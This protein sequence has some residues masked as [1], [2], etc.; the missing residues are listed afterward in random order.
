[1][2]PILFCHASRDD[3]PKKALHINPIM[4][5]LPLTKTRMAI[6]PFQSITTLGTGWD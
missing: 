6:W 1:M 2:V 4:T 3:K 5:L